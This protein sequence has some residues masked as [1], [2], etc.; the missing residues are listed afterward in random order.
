MPIQGVNLGKNSQED[1]TRGS[2]VSR[3]PNV[4]VQSAKPGGKRT[5]QFL[6]TMAFKICDSH[7]AYVG[8]SWNTLKAES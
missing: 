2:K 3:S 8:L 5:V 4:L 6:L 1:H 7:G